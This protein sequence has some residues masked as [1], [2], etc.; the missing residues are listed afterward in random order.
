MDQLFGEDG[1]R[2]AT[3]LRDILN[4]DRKIWLSP[5]STR[6]KLNIYKIM[7]DIARKRRIG[8]RPRIGSLNHTLSN[9]TDSKLRVE[10][11]TDW[12][13]VLDKEILGVLPVNCSTEFA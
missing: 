10:H 4:K 7:E 5:Q 8:L 3:E 13:L 6:M 2:D 11:T 12:F 1:K 9:T